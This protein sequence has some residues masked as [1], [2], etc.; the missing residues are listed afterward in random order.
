MTRKLALLASV[1]ALL[2]SAACADSTGPKK[3]CHVV[4]GTNSC[5]PD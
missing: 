3:D 4:N 5:T 2:A 1:A